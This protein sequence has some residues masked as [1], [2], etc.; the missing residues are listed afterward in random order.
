M[1]L[2]QRN[3]QYEIPP[4]ASKVLGVEFSGVIEDMGDQEVDS[5][6]FYRGDKVFGLTYGGK[7]AEHKLGCQTF[8]YSSM[9]LGAYAEYVCVSTLMIIH[10][11]EAISWEVAAGIPEVWITALQAMRVVGGFEATKSILWHAG[12]SS[13]SIAGIQ[14]SK[15]LG[16]SAVYATAGSDAKLDL[17]KSL[18]ATDAWNHRTSDWEQELKKATN[19][20]GVDII[21]DFVGQDYFQ[22]N[23]NST[24]RDGR[25]V[26]V[27]LLSGPK[28][29]GPVDLSLFVKQR[30]R[31]E[32]SRL[33]SR[34]LTYQKVLR[35][36]LVR[37]VL[38]RFVDGTFNHRMEKIFD[39]KD[40][41][42]AHLLMESNTI[43]GKIVC[44]VT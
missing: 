10:K 39:W 28:T 5:E 31:V 12:A 22:R 3:G 34:D 15:V 37:D 24:A 6:T 27:G 33:R 8:T 41:Q 42:A 4:Q 11:P 30:I 40:I 1:D 38:P 20:K 7:R 32:G 13:V 21:I 16:A 26:I 36:I 25:V 43:M 44:R 17:C 14:L 29:Q 35:D 23:L 2:T 18:G 9:L 19:G